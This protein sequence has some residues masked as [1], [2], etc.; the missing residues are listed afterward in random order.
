MLKRS[1]DSHAEE[2]VFKAKQMYYAFEERAVGYWGEA[3]KTKRN[4]T[5]AEK[6]RLPSL[7]SLMRPPRLE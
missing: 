7:P 6:V 2:G 5:P 4:S 1:W 3:G